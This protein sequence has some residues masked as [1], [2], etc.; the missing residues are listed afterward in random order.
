VGVNSLEGSDKPWFRVFPNPSGGI[1]TI[2]PQNATVTSLYV[3]VFDIAGRLI[4]GKQFG[5]QN[6]YSIDLSQASRGVYSLRMQNWKSVQT[7]KL[8]KN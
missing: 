7:I 4:L 2:V 1:F 6:E 5:P 3:Q 8:I